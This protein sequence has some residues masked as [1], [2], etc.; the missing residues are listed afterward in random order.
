MGDQG[1]PHTVT[2][3][4]VDFPP[5]QPV[6]AANKLKKEVTGGAPCLS[7]ITHCHSVKI[8]DVLWGLTPGEEETGLNN[9]HPDNGELTAQIC[10]LLP[11]EQKTSSL[12]L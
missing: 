2:W 6:R 10:L 3:F 9:Q 7:P 12:S 4:L 5:P 8:S 1:T 11:L